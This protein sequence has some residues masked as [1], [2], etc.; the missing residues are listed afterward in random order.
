MNNGPEPENNTS[1]PQFAKGNGTKNDSF[2]LRPAHVENFG[3]SVMSK[4]TITISKLDSNS[5]IT[6]SDMTASTNRGR[7]NID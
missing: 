4:E 2:I 1:R 6:I 5:L 7:F 3:D